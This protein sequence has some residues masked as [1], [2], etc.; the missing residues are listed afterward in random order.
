W[1]AEAFEEAAAQAGMVVTAARTFE[2]WDAHP[3]GIAVAGQPL[4]TIERIGD[5]PPQPLAA[6]ADGR[7]LSGVR[8]LDLTRVIA[9]PVCGRTLAAHGADV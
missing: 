4:M 8:V 5:A 2:E 1:K 9:G 3:Q 7:P 6:H